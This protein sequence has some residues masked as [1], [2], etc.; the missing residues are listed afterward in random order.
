MLVLARKLGERVVIANDIVVTVLAVER[1]RIKLGIE[2]PSQIPILRY[3]IY[4]SVKRAN[5]EAAALAQQA[6]GEV[7][8]SVRD[9]LRGQGPEDE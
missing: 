4:E 9:L 8:S 1:D 5:E 6:T 7:L 2:A 3:E